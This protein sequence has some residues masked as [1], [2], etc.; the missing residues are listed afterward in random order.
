MPCTFLPLLSSTHQSWSLDTLFPSFYHSYFSL[1][2]KRSP[3]GAKMLLSLSLRSLVISALSLTSLVI[4]TT[5]ANPIPQPQTDVYTPYRGELIGYMG[6]NDPASQERGV[7]D[8]K[9]ILEVTDSMFIS[10]VFEKPL[11]LNPKKPDYTTRECAISDV[12]GL[13]G[14]AQARDVLIYYEYNETLPGKYDPSSQ[15]LIMFSPWMTIGK[16]LLASHPPILLCGSL[17][18]FLSTTLLPSYSLIG[19][20]GTNRHS[21]DWSRWGIKNYPKGPNT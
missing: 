16:A 17:G 19:P 11:H 10:P 4:V 9:L 8:G 12:N 2:R 7:K 1:H 6:F 13:I 15:H 3:L 14:E 18:T 5:V 20:A 21:V